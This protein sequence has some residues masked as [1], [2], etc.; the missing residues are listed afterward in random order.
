MILYQGGKITPPSGDV[1]M[2][3][4]RELDEALIVLRD[5]ELK[6]RMRV[7][8]RVR[9]AGRELVRQRMEIVRPWVEGADSLQQATFNLKRIGVGR[10]CI[11]IVA[12]REFAPFVDTLI[13]SI[14][15]E[16]VNAAI[17]LLCVGEDFYQERLAMVDH[18]VYAA[19]LNPIGRVCNWIKF[20]QVLITE[21][22]HANNY[23]LLEADTLVADDINNLWKIMD[24]HGDKTVFGVAPTVPQH[25]MP[26]ESHLGWMAGGADDVEFICGSRTSAARF[27][28]NGGVI[29]AKGPALRQV[30][31]NAKTLWPFSQLWMEGGTS[32]RYGDEIIFN[33]AATMPNL[34]TVQLDPSWNDQNFS[35]HNT[36]KIVHTVNGMHFE[37]DGRKSKILHVIREKDL[38][39]DARPFYWE[40]ARAFNGQDA[41]STTQDFIAKHMAGAW[42]FIHP[43]NLIEACLEDLEPG[44]IC[45]FGVGSGGTINRIASLTKNTVYGFDS[46]EGLPEDWRPGFHK[47]CFKT[48]NPKVPKNVELII[49]LFSETL[50]K[51]FSVP[52][53]L[54]FM[55]CDADLESS[56]RDI[57][58]ACLPRM[59]IGTVILFDEFFGY[60][61]WQ[62]NGEFSAWDAF[63]KAHKIVYHWIGYVRDGQ[64]AA[65]MIT[66]LPNFAP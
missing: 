62:E 29:A 37:R 12:S 7:F 10:N 60:M 58:N 51:F 18:N 17:V 64:Q 30:N 23:L 15:R 44:L 26:I 45:E 31:A 46:F 66:D 22:Y 32:Q 11:G 6:D 9:R 55:H 36:S 63:S 53:K 8:P 14:H 28:F 38:P 47:G 39:G 2:P 20:A 50:P 27:P 1:P 48:E 21:V 57:L 5:G 25:V 49:G 33:W 43:Q 52:R 56:T 4:V 41:W 42:S 19:L 54:A 35:V 59:Q 16:R 65:L 3:S 61:G 24:A 40:A 13:E 34:Q